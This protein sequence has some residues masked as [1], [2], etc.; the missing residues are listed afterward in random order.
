MSDKPLRE[1]LKNAH[2][3]EPVPDFEQTWQKARAAAANP[4]SGVSLWPRVLVPAGALLVMVIIAVTVFRLS[5]LQN[6]SITPARQAGLRNTDQVLSRLAGLPIWSLAL[7]ELDT[8]G[9]TDPTD[10]DNSVD[11]AALDESDG[12]QAFAAHENEPGYDVYEAPTD[13]LLELD[14]PAWNETKQRSIL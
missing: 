13:F 6:D 10:M 12:G 7:E 3:Q 4:P 5:P 1:L 11:T 8:E 2:R 14:I 9:D